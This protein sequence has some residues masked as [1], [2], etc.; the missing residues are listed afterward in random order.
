M[1][2]VVIDLRTGAARRV[3]LSQAEIA[4]KQ[5]DEI[6]LELAKQ[7]AAATEN[8]RK[9]LEAAKAAILEALILSE[10]AKPTAAQAIKDA[11]GIIRG[12]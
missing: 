11:A 3:E 9:T 5:Q 6:T 8:S 1:S 12:R 2:K 7:A 4:Q 10:S